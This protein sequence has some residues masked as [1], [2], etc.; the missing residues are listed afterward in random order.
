MVS[1]ILIIA[2]IF[3][4]IVVGFRLA[5]HFYFCGRVSEKNP[6]EDIKGCPVWT[7]KGRKNPQNDS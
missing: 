1:V 2:G 4:T 7:Q 5:T 3:I 6:G